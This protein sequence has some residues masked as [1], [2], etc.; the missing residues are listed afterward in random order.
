MRRNSMP[1]RVTAPCIRR[2]TAYLDT[3]FFVFTGPN[4]RSGLALGGSFPAR[5]RRSYACMYVSKLAEG[6]LG[7][8]WTKNE[9]GREGEA[10]ISASQF[11]TSRMAASPTS[12][13][14]LFAATLQFSMT[15]TAS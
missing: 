11:V 6:P 13:Q 12:V 15:L 10:I 1:G 14:A 4:M 9:E 7:V 2:A 3:G 8:N 5:S